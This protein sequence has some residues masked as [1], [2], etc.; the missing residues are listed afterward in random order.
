ME[1]AYFMH[2]SPWGEDKQGVIIDCFSEHHNYPSLITL[3]SLAE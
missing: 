3:K 1:Y 2:L